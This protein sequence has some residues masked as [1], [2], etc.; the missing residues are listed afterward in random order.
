[1]DVGSI[2]VATLVLCTEPIAFVS[3]VSTP[4]AATVWSWVG[5]AGIA[6]LLII[7]GRQLIKA[8]DRERAEVRR[9]RELYAR[10]PESLRLPSV[11]RVQVAALL[12]ASFAV[13]AVGSLV[14]DYLAGA[15]AG[16]G[17]M[18]M[19]GH[20]VSRDRREAEKTVLARGRAMSSLMDASEHD[21]LMRDLRSY[22]RKPQA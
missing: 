18:L 20:R 11:P 1:M 16:L 4:L 6:V 22:Y 15:V 14:L 3:W 13:V 5:V 2:G 7:G 21:Q 19:F 10:L 12:I 8:N 9:E 17:V